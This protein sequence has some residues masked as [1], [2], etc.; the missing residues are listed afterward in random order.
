[1][2]SGMPQLDF[3]TY[4]SQIF[5]CLLVF[6]VL[7]VVI[8]FSARSIKSTIERREEILQEK[9]AHARDVECQIEKMTKDYEKKIGEAESEAE[10][11]LNSVIH[12]MN[13]EKTKKLD[14]VKNRFNDQVVR[15]DRGIS[16]I[17]VD[18]LEIF[19]NLIYN[20]SVHYVTDIIA[21]AGISYDEL[22]LKK[23]VEK[24]VG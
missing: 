16:E 13:L 3:L 15:S 21:D 17:V 6:S 10:S 22:E 23:I 11:V 1:M 8:C 18:N 2:S 24:E 12:D 19:R 7:Y 5:W 4:P 14:E 9:I 20:T